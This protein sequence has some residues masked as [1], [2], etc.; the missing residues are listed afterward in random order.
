MYSTVEDCRVLSDGSNFPRKLSTKMYLPQNL[1]QLLFNILGH[2][3][4]E[5]GM[6]QNSCFHP[7]LGNHHNY[8]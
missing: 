1:F 2:G 7:C 5:E 6:L 8:S 4:M 3:E